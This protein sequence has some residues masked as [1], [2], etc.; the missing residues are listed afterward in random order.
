M[1]RARNRFVKNLRYLC[2]V[3]VITLG[4]IS[5]VGSNGGGGG[6]AP[7]SALQLT[8]TVSAP[9]G[10]L[11]FNTPTWLGRFFAGL[12]GSPAYATIEGVNPVGAGVTVNLIEIDA[13]GNTVGNVIATATTDA[14]GAFTL[15]APEGFEPDSKYVIRAGTTE[16]L[17]AMVTSTTVDVDPLTDAVRTLITDST[18]DLTTITCTEIDEIQDEVDG[19]VQN[20]DPTGLTAMQLSNALKTEAENGEET[21]NVIKSASSNG[22]ICGEVTDNN[23]N[24]LANIRIVVRDFGDWVKRA[25]TK[26]DT[27]GNYCVNVPFGDYIIGAINR[28]DSSMA[29]CEWLTSSGGAN[30]QF[31]AEKTTI[32]DTITVTRNFELADG[33]RITGSVAAGAG[34]S[35]SEG[36]A[37]EGI[38]I[39]VRNYAGFFPVTKAKVKA[40]GTYRIN[41]APGKYLIVAR[42]RTRYTYATESYDGAG[43]ITN[44]NLGQP[45]NVTVGNTE[46]VN[47]VLDPGHAISGQVLDGP[48]GNPVTGARVR[49]DIPDGGTAEVPRTNKQG[50]YHINLEPAMYT[51]RSSGQSADVDISSTDQEQDF[52]AQVGT[53]SATL[54][55]GSSNPVS[56]AKLF[57]RSSDGSTLISQ[58]PTNS[59]GT[60]TLYSSTDG[61][62][63]LQIVIEDG[64]F[65]GSSIYSGKTRLLSGDPVNVTVEGNNLLGSL[66]LPAG[67]VLTGTVYESDGTTPAGNLRVQVRSG[68]TS[69]NDRFVWTRTK[70]DGTYTISLPEGAYERIRAGQGDTAVDINNVSI[71]AGGT[72]TQ[73]FTLP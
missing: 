2:L 73:D 69:S 51:V 70:G 25:K 7:P 15:E 31:G 50:R 8:G 46:T 52:T 18:N 48:D 28:T 60:V 33:G 56:Q 68:G 16:A 53:V 57:L 54:L 39:L 34:G 6:G 42:N 29:A 32:Y 14:D 67:G 58:E 3:G 72:T 44:R 24:P 13:S 26:T 17:D 38:E 1:K 27:S 64:R 59:D 12:L 40:G 30:I 55:D 21:S 10:Q 5:I 66:N 35:L 19:I 11:A 63:L 45:V 20:V 47:F 41:F 9:G 65:V 49:F 71:T 22:Q 4:L 23:G 61:N 37:L 36:A 43:G 62:Y